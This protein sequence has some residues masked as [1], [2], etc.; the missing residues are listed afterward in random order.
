MKNAPDR[1]IAVTAKSGVVLLE[2]TAPTSAA[3]ERAL[4]LVRGA[5]GVTQVIDRIQ[6]PTSRKTKQCGREEF[7]SSKNE[8]I[9]RDVFNPTWQARSPHRLPD[10][11]WNAAVSRI[12]AEFEEMP[13]LRVTREKRGAS[14]DSRIP[15]WCGCCAT[16]PTKDSCIENSRGEYVRR[17]A[18]P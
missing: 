5:D 12:R 8:Q 11:L 16:S 3:K 18:H 7:A 2:G 6:V 9:E 4:T 13:C 1:L 10:I 14:S 17:A 15:L